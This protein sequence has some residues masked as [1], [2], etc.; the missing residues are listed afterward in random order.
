MREPKIGDTVLYMHSSIDKIVR[1][2]AIIT[3]I[4]ASPAVQ[5]AVFNGAL[6]QTVYCRSE[7]GIQDGGW[8][9]S[10]EFGVQ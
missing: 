10:G 5:L 8:S 2:P 1:F 7:H 4:E 9:Y 6:G 3:A